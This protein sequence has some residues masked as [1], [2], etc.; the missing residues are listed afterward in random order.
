[1]SNLHTNIELILGHLVM[2]YCN[3]CKNSTQERYHRLK[4]RVIHLYIDRKS[5]EDLLQTEGKRGRGTN[6]RFFDF[7]VLMDA[8]HIFD[9]TSIRDRMAGEG[10]TKGGLIVRMMRARK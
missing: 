7:G 6:P 10:W 4:R 9:T 5:L 2:P 1:M 3:Y 8:C